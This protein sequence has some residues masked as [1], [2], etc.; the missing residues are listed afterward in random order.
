MSR[1]RLFISQPLSHCDEFQLPDEQG[2]YLTRVLRLKPGD[3]VLLF[4]GSGAEYPALITVAQKKKVLLEIG[5]AVLRNT[6]SPLKIRL[7][8]GISRGE[9]MDF[10]MQKATELGVDR[11]SPVLTE[12]SVVKLSTARAARRLLHWQKIV[13]SACEQCGRNRLPVVDP[14]STLHE[15]L[16]Q[17]TAA[18]CRLLLQPSATTSLREMPQPANGVDLL[19]GPEGGFS[20][21]EY[22]MVAHAKFSAA[23]LGPR[24]L[25]TETAALAAVTL[26]QANWGDLGGMTNATTE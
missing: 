15:F 16:R 26:L 12:F 18:E 8:Q 10:V 19:I 7:I 14:P 11:I 9:R 23:S 17:S 3:R 1:H 2:H 21:A 24:V 22:E 25:R 5:A 20:V 6:E 13:Q 4:D